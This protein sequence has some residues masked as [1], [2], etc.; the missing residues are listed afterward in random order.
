MG[1]GKKPSEALLTPVVPCED[2]ASLQEDMLEGYTNPGWLS[3]QP[4]AGIVVPRNTRRIADDPLQ[5]S[6]DHYLL[7]VG[8]QH[9]STHG[10]LR[11]ILE[12]DGERIMSGEAHVGQLH[13]GI[14]KLAEHRRYHQLATLVDRAD[15]VSGIT[16]E[17]A[18]ALATEQL[19]EIEVPPRAQWLRCLMAEVNRIASHYMWI[20]PMGLDSG[21]MGIFLYMQKDREL[22]IDVLEEMTGQRLMFNYVRPGRVTGDLTPRAEKL[23]RDYLKIGI[24]RMEEH[25]DS[26]FESELF[27]IR[28]KGIGVL[29]ADDALNYGATGHVLRASGIDF[30]VRRDRPYDAYDQFDFDVMTRT[31]GD[32]F[33]RVTCR[34]DEIRQSLRIIEQCLDGMPPGDIKA[35]MP[36]VLRVPEGEAC[37]IVESA[38]GEVGIHLY[39]D[40]SDKPVRMRYRPPTLYSLGIAEIL[41]PNMMFADAIVGMGSFDF[42]FGEV[43]R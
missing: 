12:M 9:P 1:I 14:E 35:K 32:V 33:D 8:P 15:Y 10:A 24:E 30:D 23:L 19:A 41:L 17:T 4:P 40:G 36:K 29:S 2:E 42:C 22:F 43:D 31:G 39:S 18:A 26:L 21:A 27:Q 7:N 5:L 25:W 37:G 16:V 20:G 11:V 6:T 34:F 13:R 28:T 3:P 38:R